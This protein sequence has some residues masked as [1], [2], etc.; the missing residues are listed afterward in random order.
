[1]AG[2][3]G[4]CTACCRLLGIKELAKPAGKWCSHC[5]IGK[6][7]TIYETRPESCRVYSCM[8]LSSQS[9]PEGNQWPAAL[10]PDKSKVVFTMQAN[11]QE[12]VVHCDPGRPTA[13]QYGRLGEI[14][15][16]LALE[17]TVI[18]N[19]GKAYFHIVG[20]KAKEV[21]MT[22]DDQGRMSFAG[23]VGRKTKENQK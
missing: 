7:C 11:E 22:P 9:L 8:W 20:G 23:Y 14:I 18:V 3:C 6:G 4:T 13:W 15:K 12:V 1:M 2:D 17:R 10:R 5:A 19:D 21:L 16:Y